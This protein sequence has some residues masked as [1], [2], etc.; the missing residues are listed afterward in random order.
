ML[1]IL[2]DVAELKCD[3]FYGRLPKWL[4]AMVAY[5]KA[6]PQEKTYSDFLQAQHGKQRRKNPW[7]Y[8]IAPKAKQV[9]TPPNPR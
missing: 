6:S 3:H 5:L 1:P 8:P 7:N 9:I 2:T 4:K